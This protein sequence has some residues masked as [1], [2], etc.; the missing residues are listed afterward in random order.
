MPFRL[1]G[2]SRSSTPPTLKNLRRFPLCQY[3]AGLSPDFLLLLQSGFWLL[4][5]FYKLSPSNAHFLDAD[6]QRM[7]LPAFCSRFPPSTIRVWRK[8]HFCNKKYEE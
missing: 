6:R 5:T 8:L 1:G 4:E 3:I 2:E 7:S